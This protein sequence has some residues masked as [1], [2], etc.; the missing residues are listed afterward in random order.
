MAVIG[1]KWSLRPN[2]HPTGLWPTSAHLYKKV[3]TQGE[4]VF[5]R[6][7]SEHHLED[8]SF[9]QFGRLC[10][11]CGGGFGPETA[12]R[13]HFDASRLPVSFQKWRHSLHALHGKTDGRHQIRLQVNQTKNCWFF[14]IWMKN[15]PQ[16]GPQHSSELPAWCWTGHQ[17]LGPR[18]HR[19]VRRWKPCFDYSSVAG[20][21]KSWSWWCHS[22][23]YVGSCWIFLNFFAHEMCCFFRCNSAVWRDTGR[24]PIL[25]IG[26]KKRNRFLFLT[27]LFK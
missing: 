26:W 17:G 7:W 13:R 23:R 20:L 1:V 19:H 16:F 15:L 10:L 2:G 21:R 14:F 5:Q 11:S 8:A 9:L 25:V 24:H 6:P 27:F 4:Q 18:S 22:S 3:A 12:D